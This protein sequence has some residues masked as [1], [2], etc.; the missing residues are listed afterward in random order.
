MELQTDNDQIAMECNNNETPPSSSNHGNDAD[1][2]SVVIEDDNNDAGYLDIEELGHIVVHRREGPLPSAPQPAMSRPEHR[3]SNNIVHKYW[4]PRTSPKPPLPPRPKKREVQ[5]DDGYARP[6]EPIPVT[7]F[8]S[9]GNL[10]TIHRSRE[11]LSSDHPSSCPSAFQL[12]EKELRDSNNI[13]VFGTRE[14]VRVFQMT[15]NINYI[16]II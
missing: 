10:P 15:D 3:I 13:P 5:A 1:D 8:L 7:R 9:C 2:A 12:F 4:Y 11:Q 6:Y 16:L 14:E